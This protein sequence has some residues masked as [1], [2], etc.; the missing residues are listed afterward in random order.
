MRTIL[1]RARALPLA[2]SL[3]LA[4]LGCAAAQTLPCPAALSIET[5]VN[6]PPG[7][8][9]FAGKA[10][11]TLRQVGLYMGAPEA[12]ASLVPDSVVDGA[13]ESRDQWQLAIARAETAWV[14]CF[15]AGTDTFL[16]RPLDRGVSRCS[17]HYLTSAGGVRLGV[18]RL[19]CE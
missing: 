10:A 8:K 18:T 13:R 1:A 17:A 3:A 4:M 15:Y 19:S 9:A 2:L 5:S 7:W 14:A 16:A 6:A 11:H 12:G